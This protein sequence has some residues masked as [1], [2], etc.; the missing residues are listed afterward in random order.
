[1]LRLYVSQ[2]MDEIT[3]EIRDPCRKLIGE[4]AEILPVAGFQQFLVTADAGIGK[5][6][7]CSCF[8]KQFFRNQRKRSDYDRVFRILRIGDRSH[9]ADALTPAQTH[10]KRSNQIVEMLAESKF[11]AF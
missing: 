3:A 7:F 1:M 9:G 6:I 8:R 11:V 5:S 2:R 4:I 10:E